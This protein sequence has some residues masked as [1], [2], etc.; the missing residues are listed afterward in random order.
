[1]VV[2]IGEQRVMGQG[3]LQAERIKPRELRLYSIHT[4][5]REVGMRMWEVRCFIDKPRETAT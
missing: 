4:Q 2:H 3:T 5:T 1:M